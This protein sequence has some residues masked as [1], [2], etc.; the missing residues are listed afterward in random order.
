[1]VTLNRDILEEIVS[2]FNIE[3][4]PNEEEAVKALQTF[5]R[6]G[7]ESYEAA[8]RYFSHV[9]TVVIGDKQIEIFV[10]RHV[11]SEPDEYNLYKFPYDFDL[12]NDILGVLE[13]TNKNLEI[14]AYPESS[15][16][17]K[18]LARLTQKPIH[19]FTKLIVESMPNLKKLDTDFSACPKRPMFTWKKVYKQ[20]KKLNSEMFQHIPIQVKG[21][22]RFFVNDF[23]QSFKMAVKSIP[24]TDL[25]IDVDL[26]ERKLLK[27]FDIHDGL[28]FEFV[29]Q[30]CE[31]NDSEDGSA[32]AIDPDSY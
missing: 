12:L 14:E 30:F 24:K 25:G 26:V 20:M 6:S 3:T 9:D 11:V 29:L 19:D 16:G 31:K 27:K 23:P 2:Q 18:A 21:A 5:M 1:M 22:M 15:A 7:K 13:D 4:I 32:D 28:Y 8:L 17:R 10:K